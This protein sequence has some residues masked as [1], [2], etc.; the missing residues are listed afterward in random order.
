MSSLGVAQEQKSEFKNQKMSVTP[1]GSIKS[2]SFL[3]FKEW[4]DDTDLKAVYPE[5]QKILTERNLKEKVGNVFECVGI[6]RIDRGESFFNASHRTNVYEGDEFQT[7]G[8]SYAWIFLLDGTMVRLSPNSSITFN[9]FNV[10]VENNFI[11][12]RFNSGNI[13]WLSR[14]ES[15]FEELNI[16]ETDVLFLPLKTYEANP[17]TDNKA[18]LEYDLLE[19]VEDNQ[20]H[21]NHYKALNA[22]VAKNNEMTHQKKTYAF[23]V[24]PNATI[25][26]TSPNVEAVVLI[27]GKSYFKNRSNITLGLT[28]PQTND[29]QLQMRGFENKELKVF[30]EDSWMVVD[31]KGRTLGLQE[32][33]HLLTMGEFITKRIPSIMMGREIFLQEYSPFVFNQKI[34]PVV[35]ASDQGYRLWNKTDLDSR[36]SF[37]TEYFRRVETSN[38]LTSA[39]FI[40][41]LEERGDVAG[42]KRQVMEYGR[43]FFIKAL[44]SYYTYQD[45]PITKEYNPDKENL[46]STQKLLWKKMHGIR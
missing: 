8:E 19:M 36:L 29:L 31:E 26:G 9:E 22:A 40:R 10:G 4:R 42:A 43:Q 7:V 37:L 14:S 2:D 3:S 18:Y 41:R 33:S 23:L 44:N 38:L 15:L 24:M 45:D 32:Q 30:S 20:T 35:L 25:M 34:D 46:N 21:L 13:L 5:W 28:T 11:N 6:C 27:G 12:A 17:I 39:S 1:W 16:R